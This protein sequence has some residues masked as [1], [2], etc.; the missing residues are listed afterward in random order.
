MEKTLILFDVDGTLTESRKEIKQ[1]MIDNLTSLKLITHLDIGI[2]G[3]SNLDK[4][5]E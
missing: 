3:G 2:V 5:K 4:Q 1:N